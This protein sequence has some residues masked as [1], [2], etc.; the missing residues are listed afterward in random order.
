LQSRLK[1]G[2]PDLAAEELVTII[3]MAEGK[4]AELLSAQPEVKRMDKVL[5][6]LP[7]AAAQY[8]QQITKGLPG[9][10]GGGRP[11]PHCGA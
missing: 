1:A 6:A 4:R 5:H 9:Q 10:P 3:Q 8:R 11:R 2:D 7:A